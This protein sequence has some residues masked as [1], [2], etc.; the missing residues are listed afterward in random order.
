M[1]GAKGKILTSVYSFMLA[2]SASS[3]YNLLLAFV[4]IKF[5]YESRL[6]DCTTS[7]VSVLH[8]CAGVAGL[9]LTLNNYIGE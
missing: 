5:I 6:F 1:F 3:A 7:S 4:S 2:L 9:N 8:L